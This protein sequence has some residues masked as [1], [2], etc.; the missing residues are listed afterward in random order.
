MDTDLDKQNQLWVLVM[1]LAAFLVAYASPVK[2]TGTDPRGALLT[3]QAIVTYGTVKL[4][5]YYPGGTP[6]A[7]FQIQ[8]KNGHQYYYFPIGTSVSSLPFVWLAHLRGDD[9]FDAASDDALQ[10][11]LSAL[12]VTTACVLMYMI[13]RRYLAVGSSLLVTSAFS[14]GSSIASTMGAALWNLDFETVFL[15]AG[16]L[17]A[18]HASTRWSWRRSVALGTLLFLAYLCRPTASVAVVAIVSAVWA[19]RRKV[20]VAVVGTVLVWLA[21]L[22]WFSWKEYRQLLP[23]YYSPSRLS[24]T[25]TFLTAVYGNLLGPS[26]GVFVYSPFLLITLGGVAASAKQL[27]RLPWFWAATAWVVCHLIVISRF[28]PWW[29]GDSFG[30]R[31]FTDGMP[32][33]FVLTCLALR[34]IGGGVPSSRPALVGKSVTWLFA[35]LATLG[36][37]INTFQGLFNLHTL[38]W[39]GTVDYATFP[40]YLLNWRFPQFLASPRLLA[41]REAAHQQR[42]GTTARTE[43]AAVQAVAEKSQTQ[44]SLARLASVASRAHADCTA[45]WA[46]NRLRAGAAALSSDDVLT[47][48]R[49]LTGCVADRP[50]MIGP[51][52]LKNANFMSGLDDWIHAPEWPA[53]VQAVEDGDRHART[54]HVTYST[55]DWRVIAQVLELESDGYYAVEMS[56]RSTAPIVTLYREVEGGHYAGEGVFPV[57]KTVREVFAVRSSSAAVK[58]MPVG[59]YPVLMK[60]P[61]EA[62]IRNL[63]LARVKTE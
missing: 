25:T 42:L 38:Q 12:C 46:F 8:K 28:S 53:R 47:S 31:F 30:S 21:T 44:E 16:V 14:F 62:W 52:L 33:L 4:D 32:G 51:N 55:G 24:G 61:G 50:D 7:T 6:P 36:V 18:H 11:L 59:F 27:R 48:A 49:A 41:A 17:L 22:A 63:K 15:F 10:N 19:I 26:R 13:S 2:Y 34:Q 20:P 1:C 45:V 37:F 54:L 9:M 57:W 23:D 56:V 58:S 43:L 39:T 5:T 3:S 60:G 40:D 35:G 29:G